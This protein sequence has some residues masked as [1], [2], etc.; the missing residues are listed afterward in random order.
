MS[1]TDPIA[2]M[3]A[4]IRNSVM[5][6][7]HDLELPSSKIK[8]AIAKLMKEEGFIGDYRVAKEAGHD[9]LAIKLNYYEGKSAIS[10]LKRISKPGRRIYCRKDE[11]PHVNK[12][13]GMAVISTSM[14]LMT[15]IQARQ[16]GV[17]GEILLTVW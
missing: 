11:I 15:D 2:D 12:G 16:A 1:M 3:L 9:K 8:V 7:H 5:V 13:I 6:K 17:G 10:G 4:R 14:G